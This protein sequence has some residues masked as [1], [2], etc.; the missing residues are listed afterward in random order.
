MIAPDFDS[1]DYY[2]LRAVEWADDLRERR[3]L[4]NGHEVLARY[5]A[6]LIELSGPLQGAAFL[7]AGLS[8]LHAIEHEYYEDTLT[9]TE[10]WTR[11]TR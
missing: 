5:A 11:P 7:R 9:L 1:P 10:A 6:H 8:A 3:S 2:A 4:T